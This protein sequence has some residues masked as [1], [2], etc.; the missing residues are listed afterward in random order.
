MDLWCLH[1]NLQHPSVWHPWRRAWDPWQLRLE[2]LWLT[3]TDG[4]WPWAETF[5]RKVAQSSSRP[6]VLMGYSM[7]GRLALHAILQDPTLW[8][9]SII[10]SADPGLTSKSARVQQLQK[11][12]IWAQRFLTDPGE[13]VWR[14]WDAMPIFGG[15][16]HPQRRDEH[17]FSKGSI[18]HLFEAFSKGHQADLRP[19]LQQ[20]QT[21]PILY[22]SGEQ[23]PKYTNIGQQLAHQ[24]PIVTHQI[25]SQAAHRVPWDQPELFQQAVAHFIAP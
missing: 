6:S 19:R 2:N 9:G 16:S 7:G 12:R 18:A 15:H 13:T 14:D 21:P 24:C 3:E 1:G 11:D 5:C 4:L 17:E 23:D 25:I 10:I 22:L 20:L 8:Q